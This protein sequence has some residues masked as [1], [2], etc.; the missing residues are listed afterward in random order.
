MV[1]ECGEECWRGIRNHSDPKCRRNNI[2]NGQPVTMGRIS[3]TLK[4]K[5]LHS[6][7]RN[8]SKWTG[9]Y[10]TFI[11]KWKSAA[12][13]ENC[14]ILMG[15]KCLTPHFVH[16]KN[17]AHEINSKHILQSKLRH[18]LTSMFKLNILFAQRILWIFWPCSFRLVLRAL[19]FPIL[20]CISLN[21]RHLLSA[22]NTHG[23]FCQLWFGLTKWNVLMLSHCYFIWIK[24][25]QM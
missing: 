8:I 21:I 23:F 12:I 24:K 15:W 1:S 2:S 14:N 19:E 7:P 16:S 9:R 3:R 5:W 18:T 10:L 20:M 13:N 6:F 4:Q 25:N 11:S 17:L 22:W